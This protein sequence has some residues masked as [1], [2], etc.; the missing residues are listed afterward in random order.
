MGQNGRV[1]GL[2]GIL[3][4][5]FGAHFQMIVNTCCIKVRSPAFPSMIA[6]VMLPGLFSTAHRYLFSFKGLNVLF[7]LLHCG[8]RRITPDKERQYRAEATRDHDKRKGI[9]YSQRGCMLEEALAHRSV[10]VKFGCCAGGYSS[11]E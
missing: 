4:R 2:R 3:T 8:K 1:D 5:A 11:G 7:V 10:M 6:I 9:V